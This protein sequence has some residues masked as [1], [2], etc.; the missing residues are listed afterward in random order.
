MSEGESAPVLQSLYDHLYRPENLYRHKWQAGDVLMWDNVGAHH[1]AITDYKLPQ[2][3]Y[4]IRTSVSGT[5]VF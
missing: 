4:L 3:R 1:M 2:R 5:P